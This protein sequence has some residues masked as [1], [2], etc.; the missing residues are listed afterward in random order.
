MDKVC[1]SAYIAGPMIQTPHCDWPVTTHLSDWEQSGA[2]WPVGVECSVSLGWDLDFTYP[3]DTFPSLTIFIPS[4]YIT[5]T[6]MYQLRL[7]HHQP[8][9]VMTSHSPSALHIHYHKV[10]Y[11]SSLLLAQF[12]PFLLGH[13]LA[14]I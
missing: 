10:P 7:V 11:F 4:C 3:F 14:F 5:P 2:K 13:P 8:I 9:P 1:T 12:S 6:G